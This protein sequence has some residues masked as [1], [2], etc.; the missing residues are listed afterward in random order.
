M[1]KF[2]INIM[3]FLIILLVI[4]IIIFLGINIIQSMVLDN[5]SLNYSLD[6][7]ISKLVIDTNKINI[8][9]AGDSRAERQLSP[10]IICKNTGL[11]T[12]NI[13]VGGCDLV[14]TTAAIKNKY[15]SCSKMVFIIGVSSSQINDGAIDRGYFFLKS[16]QKMTLWE[17]FILYKSNLWEMPRTQ[18]QLLGK[19]IDKFNNKIPEYDESIIKELGFM[20]ID[21]SLIS[22]FRNINIERLKNSHPWYKDLNQNGALWIEFKKALSEIGNMNAFFI[23]YQPPI[24][25]YWKINTAKSVIDLAEKEYSKKLANEIQ[26]YNNILFL[27]FYTNEINELN[28]NMYYDVQHLNIKGAE[29]FSVLLSKKILEVYQ[30]NFKEN[31]RI[32]TNTVK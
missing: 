22:S 19:V 16:F 31:Y 25:P 32:I 2:L 21:S 9:I 13:A 29:V 5:D 23:L 7:K 18:F 6:S 8:I 26:K 30:T 11:N 24:S 17:K 15:P 20:G 28:D 4:N 10:K 27:D 14:T 12:I 3:W 1:R